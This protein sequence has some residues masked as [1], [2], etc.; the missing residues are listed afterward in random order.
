MQGGDFTQRT[1]KG[2]ESIYGGTFED[3]DLKR[4][5]DAEG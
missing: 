1:G 2:G 5:I 3:E 4:L